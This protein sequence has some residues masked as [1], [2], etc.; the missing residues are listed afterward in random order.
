MCINLNVS[1]QTV[2]HPSPEFQFKKKKE[3]LPNFSTLPD[4]PWYS[5]GHFNPCKWLIWQRSALQQNLQCFLLYNNFSNFVQINLKKKQKQKWLKLRH[6]V[7]IVSHYLVIISHYAHSPKKKE[8]HTSTWN[9][10]SDPQSIIA[11][12]YKLD[13]LYHLKYHYIQSEQNL[14]IKSTKDSL[15]IKA[16]I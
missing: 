7:L 6:S 11:R 15:T 10:C 5:L 14:K 2:S 3:I 12:I 8:H 16:N 13:A 1:Q 4:S 9:V